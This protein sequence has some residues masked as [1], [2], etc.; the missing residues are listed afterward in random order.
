MKKQDRYNFSL[1][2]K[3]RNK[4]V[5]LNRAKVLTILSIKRKNKE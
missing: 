4:E 1:I 2:L 3:M 5:M